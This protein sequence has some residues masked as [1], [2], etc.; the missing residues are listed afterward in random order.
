MGIQPIRFFRGLDPVQS[1]FYEVDFRPIGLL[2]GRG[3]V[4][5]D[6]EELGVQPIRFLQGRVKDAT[7]ML[8]VLGSYAPVPVQDLETGYSVPLGIY[9]TDI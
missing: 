1:D 3:D 8:Q 6:F 7:V 5:A 9:V 4:Q 2:E